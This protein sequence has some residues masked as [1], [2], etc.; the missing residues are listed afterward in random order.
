MPVG[1]L[2]PTFCNNCY[3]QLFLTN[4]WTIP[5]LYE[6]DTNDNDKDKNDG[7]GNDSVGNDSD[8]DNSDDKGNERQSFFNERKGKKVPANSWMYSRWHK[9]GMCLKIS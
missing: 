3:S 1:S 8:G 6:T 5:L 9:C 4:L 2:F 7:V